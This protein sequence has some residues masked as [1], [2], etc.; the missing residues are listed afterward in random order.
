M[1]VCGLPGLLYISTTVNC[2]VDDGKR[3][4]YLCVR[5]CFALLGCV[6]KLDCRVVDNEM[7]T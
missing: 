2:D 6:C 5:S 7:G 1:A 4:V 3:M